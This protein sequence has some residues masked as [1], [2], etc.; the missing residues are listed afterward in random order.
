AAASETAKYMV[1]AWKL[2]ERRKT[3]QE[4]AADAAKPDGLR[5]SVLD[6]WVKY[7]FEKDAATR[8]TLANWRKATA[9]LDAG[10]DLSSDAAALETVKA[11][12]E[13]FQKEV[14][15]AVK[16][17]RKRSALL[18]EVVSAQGVYRIDPNQV[19]KTLG[20]E[21]RK[22]LGELRREAETLKKN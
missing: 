17:N 21:A 3:R 1:A 10:K 14:L 4:S 9:G 19:E 16:E 18:Q 13:A 7:L 2:N 20:D 6:R 8:Q 22:K 11:A 5:E 15:A 12:A